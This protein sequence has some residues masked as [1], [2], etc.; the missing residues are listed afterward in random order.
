MSNDLQALVPRIL[1]QAL[2]TLRENVVLPQLVRTDLSAEAKQRGQTV[3]V[4]IPFGMGEA[5]EVVPSHLHSPTQDIAPAYARI[6][7]NRWFEKK[8][9]LTDK[10]AGDIMD[11]IIPMQLQEAARSL[12]NRIDKDI[13]NLY[14]KVPNVIG[15]AGQTPFQDVTDPT[16][17]YHKL[18]AALEARRILNRNLAPQEDRRLV[19]N[20]DADAN[21]SGLRGFQ[22]AADF[23]SDSVV[24][25]GQIRRASGYD[26]FMSQN[27]P[28]HVNGTTGTVVTNGSPPLV[29]KAGD[30]TL[31]VSGATAVGVGDKFSIAGHSQ[32]Y[33]ILENSTTTTFLIYPGLVVDVPTSSAVTVYSSGAGADISLAFHPW[34]FAF[35]ARPML[36][37]VAPGSIVESYVDNVTGIPLRLE[38]ARQNRQ[39]VFMLDILYGVDVLRPELAV[40][41]YG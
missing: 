19:L 7:L 33:T 6:A 35:V 3:D 13:W 1:A 22:S 2:K 16:Q 27:S 10:D 36:D 25:N 24:R 29:N 5:D 41:I 4:P 37:V 11:G 39:T 30:T 21:A 23:G 31:I 9:Y 14:K 15:T 28:T 20:V 40:A 34:A 26:W 17:V 8:L 12:A 18:G 38:I 32:Q